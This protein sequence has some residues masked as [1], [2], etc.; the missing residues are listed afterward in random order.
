MLQS[1]GLQ[2]V[3]HKL[4]TEQQQQYIINFILS[5]VQFNCSVVSDSFRPH[6]LQQ[7]R[8]PCLSTTPGVYSNPWPSSQ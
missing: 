7:A 5:S 6:E 3:G 8:P 4:A 2:R 1:M